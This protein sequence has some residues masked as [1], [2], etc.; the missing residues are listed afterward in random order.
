MNV[1]AKRFVAMVKA[2]GVK[3]SLVAKELGMSVERLKKMLIIREP[4]TYTESQALLAMF[5]AEQMAGVIDWR[6]VY[7]CC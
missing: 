2:N 4:F 7:A 6:V 3:A 5:G 1:I